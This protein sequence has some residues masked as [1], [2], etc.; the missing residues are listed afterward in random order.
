MWAAFAVLMSAGIMPAQAASDLPSSFVDRVDTFSSTLS[1]IVFVQINILSTPVEVIALWLAAP[2]VIFTVYFG[3]INLRC[4]KLA[5]KILRGCYR[6]PEAPGEVS[7]FQALSTALSGTVGLGNIAGVA[8]AIAIGGPGA[9][10][11]M[12]IIAFFA[13]ALKFCECTMAVKYRVLH[14]NGTVSGG[15][16]YYLKLGLEA[17]GWPRLGHLLAAS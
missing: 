15:P 13:M 9:A 2:M 11:W 16:M 5:Y 10:L 7:Q 17:R 1:D 3:F 14:E 8:I 4:F 12:V 6:D